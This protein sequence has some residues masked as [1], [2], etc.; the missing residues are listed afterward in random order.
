MPAWRPNLDRSELPAIVPTGRRSRHFAL[1]IR[2]LLLPLLATLIAGAAIAASEEGAPPA[3]AAAVATHEPFLQPN[4]VVVLADR[5]VCTLLSSAQTSAGIVGQDG[6]DTVA[7]NGVVY[8]NFGDTE[9]SDGSLIPNNLAWSNDRDASDCITLQPKE[10]SG[11]AEP[12]LSHTAG[13]E[14]TV[15]PLGMVSTGPGRVYFYYAS[16]V[17]DP[18]TSWRVAGVGL[19]TLDTTTLSAERAL[20]GE[21]LWPDGMPLPSHAFVDNQYVY[22][23]LGAWRKEWVSDTFLARVP[24]D[25]IASPEQYEYWEPGRGGV[26][27]RWV[28]GL[29]NAVTQS[30]SPEVANIRPLWSQPG[31]HN[32]TEV[33][34]NPFLKRWL[35]VY[36]T[37]FMTSLK[38]RSAEQLTGP[39]DAV[40]TV[41]VDCLSY[42]RLPDEGYTCYTGTQHEPYMKDGGRTIY[43]SYSNSDSYQVYLHEIRFGAGV[44]QWTDDRGHALYLPA[45]AKPPDGFHAEGL[46]FYASDIPVPGLSAIH[47]WLNTKTGDVRYAAMPPFPQEAQQDLGVDFYAPVDA[48]TAGAQRA[49]YAPVYRWSLGDVDRYSPLNLADAGFSR[50][51]T[52]FYAACPD[53]D[54]DG[55]TDCLESFI[56]TDLN[57]ADTDGDRLPD[58]YERTTEGCDPLAYNDDGDGA[59][60]LVEIIA[61]S[62]PCLNDVN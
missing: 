16:V 42:Y 3:P 55:L 62:N 44:R 20:G 26:A 37:G 51:E 21:L 4:P 61:S 12:M 49:L 27:G 23:L 5:F 54:G 47:R 56:G 24:K 29:W 1:S 28:S 15:W 19:A 13:T 50:H 18:Q 8:W 59:D 6:S 35:A 60:P 43:V 11:K 38:V 14:T 25:A 10:A 33:A 46:A 45:A 2:L 30:W 34:Y 17:A 52:A 57:N 40:D 9:M 39:W 31:Y 58:G 22:V 41:L 7:A 48:A 36:T 32:G 53:T